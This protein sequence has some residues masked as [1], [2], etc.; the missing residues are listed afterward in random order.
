MHTQSAALRVWLLAESSTTGDE[1]ASRLLSQGL[2]V[3]RPDVDAPSHDPQAIVVIVVDEAMDLAELLAICDRWSR[4][5]LFVATT[6]GLAR[7]LADAL[8]TP[9]EVSLVTDPVELLARRL[10]R[11]ASQALVN[12]AGSNFDVDYVTGL[13]TRRRFD[14]YLTTAV[15]EVGPGQWTALVLLNLD[16]FKSINDEFCH[17]AGDQVLREAATLLKRNAAPSDRIGRWG[18]DGFAYLFSRYDA[19][20]LVA[21]GR[22]LVQRISAHEFHITMECPPAVLRV[23]ASGGLTFLR[24]GIEPKR[25]FE[26]ADLAMYEAKTAGRD[27]LVVYDSL[28]EAAQSADKDLR[29][30]H[31]E[32]VTRVASERV[33][34]M[35]TLMGRKLVEA[36]RLEANQDALTG[37]HNRRYLDSQLE[38]EIE[39]ARRLRR[40]LAI[41]MMDIDHFHDINMTYG[42]PGGDRVLQSFAQIARDSVRIADWMARYGGEEFMLVMP[43][44]PLAAARE[45]AERVRQGFATADASNGAGRPIRSTVSIGVAALD[46]D[47]ADRAALVERASAALLEAKEAGRNR[48]EVW[49]GR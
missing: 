5:L 28:A 6:E 46:S 42:W 2:Q 12:P 48:V 49:S 32:N 39:R 29:L 38:R 35:I 21:D 8:P 24:P 47:T 13:A 22:R 20:T 37:L 7:Q 30:Q 41:A 36:A 23:T 19:D 34:Q 45:I 27:R 43:E 9:H 25:L 26:E 1:L 44:T 4:A 17:M 16:R 14:E 31:F 18:G 11:L 40:P 3:K 15:E 33:V 10:R